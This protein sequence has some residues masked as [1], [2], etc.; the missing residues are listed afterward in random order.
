MSFPWVL[1]ALSRNLADLAASSSTTV[2]DSIGNG[3]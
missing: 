1:P 2:F 3:S